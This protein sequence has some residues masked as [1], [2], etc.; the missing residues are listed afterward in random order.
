MKS[1]FLNSYNWVCNTATALNPKTTAKTAIALF[2]GIVLLTPTAALAGRFTDQVRGQLMQVAISLGIGSYQLTHNPLVDDL[3]NNQSETLN[4]NLR[5]GTSY[6][7]VGVC[8]EDCRDIDL[9]VYD[10]NGNLVDSDTDT[11]D[12]PM[13]RVNPRWSGRFRV[14]VTMAN[15]TA[16]TCYYGVGVFGR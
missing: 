7:F 13:V 4:I 15:C 8:D 10:E 16:S 2:S 3:R 5:S 6:A 14:K 12:Y 9:Q 1:I 11:D